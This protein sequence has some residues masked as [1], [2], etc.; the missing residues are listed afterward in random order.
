M[1]G[2]RGPG[3]R[4]GR[5]EEAQA[6]ADL[7]PAAGMPVPV[8]GEHRKAPERLPSAAETP[9]EQRVSRRS[10]GSRAGQTPWGAGSMRCGSPRC[11]GLKRERGPARAKARATARGSSAPKGGSGVLGPWPWDQGGEAQVPRRAR[12]GRPRIP[13]SSRT[14]RTGAEGAQRTW[15][16]VPAHPSERA[17]GA[18]PHERQRASCAREAGG[19]ASRR[20][21]GKPRGR[22][23]AGEASPRETAPSG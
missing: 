19:G 5:P 1:E 8:G 18:E 13:Q 15:R 14:G 20:G 2:S 12:S 4:V 11:S 22:K 6:S 21:G 3:N 16:H 9:R 23:V 7:Q 10:A 17:P